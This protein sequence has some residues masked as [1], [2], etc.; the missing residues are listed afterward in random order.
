MSLNVPRAALAA[1]GHEDRLSFLEHLSELRARLIVSGAVLA[2]SFGF[3]FWQNHALLNVLNR[4]LAQ[5][6][7]SAVEHAH[8]PLAQSALIQQRL[9]MALDQQ[10]AAFQLLARSTTLRDPASRQALASAAR[11]DAAVVA[12]TPTVSQGRQPVTLG[13]GEP[14]GQT[15][16]VSAYFALLLALPVI[17]WQL[18][19]F[20]IPAFSPRE[21][22]VALPLMVLAPVLFVAGLVFGYFVVLPGAVGFLQNFN[23]S[24]FDTLVQARTYYQFILLTLLATGLF[25]QIPVAVIGLNRMGIVTTR[26]LRRHRRHAIVL[27]TALALLLPGTDTVTT[28]LELIPM[29][30]LY[31]LS[32]IV[33]AMFERRS[34]RPTDAY[35]EQEH[36]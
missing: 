19:A 2:V 17:L 35:T 11:A 14:F 23:S 31:E 21:R 13:I 12:I 9:R 4:P 15:V 32:I 26:Q 29:L 33:A 27:L 7:A 18:Y 30:I 28:V 3:A 16:T 34:A 6:T 20:V 10:R 25:F 8:G 5:A 36:R 1:I 24:S 22:R